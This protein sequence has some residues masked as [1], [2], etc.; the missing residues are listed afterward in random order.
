MPQRPRFVLGAGDAVETQTFDDYPENAPSDM[1]VVEARFGVF[2]MVVTPTCHVSEGEKDEDIVAVVPVQA[3][4][5]VVR[6]VTEARNIRAGK[7]VPLHVFHLP[8]TALGGGI[9]GFHGA[10]LL[11]RPAS[12]LKDNLRDYRRLGLYVESRI[13]LRKALA[14][15]WARGDAAGSIERSMRPQI[16]NRALDDLE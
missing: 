3:L 4:N 11:D 1:I 12:M 13:K 9:V 7:N 14:R 15:F 2:G 16:Q 6:D 5:L 10:A 8:P